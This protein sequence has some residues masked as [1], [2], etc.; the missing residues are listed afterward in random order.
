[1]SE[2]NVTRLNLIMNNEGL[3]KLPVCC[4]VHGFCKLCLHWIFKK[5]VDLA[6][7]VEDLCPPSQTQVLNLD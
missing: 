3:K 2:V 4:T 5:V 1:M 7:G 6:K